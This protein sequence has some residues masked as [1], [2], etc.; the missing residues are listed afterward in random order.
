MQTVLEIRHLD[1]ENKPPSFLLDLPPPS[2]GLYRPEI[3]K[4]RVL[5]GGQTKENTVL[6]P[7]GEAGQTRRMPDR[8][9]EEKCKKKDTAAWAGK[10]TKIDKTWQLDSIRAFLNA[11]LLQ[12]RAL[13]VNVRYIIALQYILYI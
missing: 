9:P 11:K 7:T 4:P 12:S 10:Q 6:I 3:R 2:F 13:Q 5:F 8:Q 1:S